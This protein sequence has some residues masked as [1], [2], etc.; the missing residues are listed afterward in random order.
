MG[1]Y[2]RIDDT[3][4]YLGLRE[5]IGAIGRA[6]K[7]PG[8]EER[9]GEDFLID[10]IRKEYGLDIGHKELGRLY[11]SDGGTYYLSVRADKIL[12]VLFRVVKSDKMLKG[13]VL[14]HRDYDPKAPCRENAAPG[15]VAKL[16]PYD[17]RDD[18]AHLIEMLRNLDDR[19]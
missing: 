10:E 4:R 1:K 18:I 13:F 14:S 12:A 7:G 3:I 8:S 15:L 9:R 6:H 5:I 16:T 2:I 17:F 19:C 11:E